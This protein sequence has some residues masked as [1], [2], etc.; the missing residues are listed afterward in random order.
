V[1]DT[2][3]EDVGEIIPEETIE[4][5]PLPIETEEIVAPEIIEEATTDPSTEIIAEPTPVEEVEIIENN[6]V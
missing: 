4:P 5:E 6:V 1:E 2:I 3:I